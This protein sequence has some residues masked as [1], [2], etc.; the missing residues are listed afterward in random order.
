MYKIFT[1]NIVRLYPIEMVRYVLSWLY[2]APIILKTHR[3]IGCVWHSVACLTFKKFHADPDQIFIRSFMSIS[4]EWIPSFLTLKKFRVDPD[5]SVPYGISCCLETSSALVIGTAIRD[6]V[7]KAARL[8]VYE[9][10][11]ISTKNHQSI[12]T[13]LV[14]IAW[15]M[16]SQPSEIENQVL[17]KQRVSKYSQTCV[18]NHFYTRNVC[19]SQTC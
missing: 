13:I 18:N 17:N 16:M 7:R 2:S 8:A 12:A 10:T 19:L 1:L 11:R 6:I 4:T 14:E 5:R 3:P 15:G 9:D